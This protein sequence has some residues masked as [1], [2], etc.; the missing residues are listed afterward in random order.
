M[1]LI[2]YD[3]NENWQ[4]G[5][6]INNMVV[7]AAWAI[8]MAKIDLPEVSN[9]II[10]QLAPDQQVKLEQIAIETVESNEG[11]V[12]EISDLQLGPPVPDPDKIICLGLNYRSHSDETGLATYSV[13]ILFSKYRNAL[14]GALD[15]IV[16]P[17]VSQEID[18]EAELAV[19]IGRRCKN[20]HREGAL[21]YVAG[22]MAFN[23]ITARDLQFSTSQWLAGKSLDTFAPCGPALVINEIHDPQNLSITTRING[24]TMQQGN[25]SNMIFPIAE[26]IE[27]ISKLM[28]LEPGD[29]IATGTPDGVGFKR[30]PP[31]F[32][33]DGDVV[34]VEVE[35]IGLLRNPVSRSALHLQKY[36]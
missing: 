32:L 5:I 12:Y 11:S 2:T 15:T 3:K 10:L 4:S 35:G 19:V 20:V 21:S 31:V 22:Y 9:R 34:E 14:I 1:R 28:T 16:L 33:R 24:Q 8:S 27:Y 36:F 6:Q 17:E 23:D 13:P 18:Y 29:I 30:K 26:T 7:D 25:T